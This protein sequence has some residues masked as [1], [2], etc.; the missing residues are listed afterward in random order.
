M[1][2]LIMKVH[3]FV[4]T[5][6][7]GR[8]GRS[9]AGRPMLVLKTIGRKSGEPRTAM[10]LYVRDGENFAVVGSHGGG[11]HHPAWYHNLKADPDAEIQ[12]GR[13]VIPVRAHVAEGEERDRIWTKADEVNKGV[14]GR[15]QL[16]TDRQIPVVVLEPR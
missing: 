10:L 2:R 8:V 14:Y 6:T 1:Q 11:A 16:G 3:H 12:V 13:S 4:F 7:D 15:Y 9:L 5:R